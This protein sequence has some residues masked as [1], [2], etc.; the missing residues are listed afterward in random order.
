MNF[1]M[2]GRL[3]AQILTIESLFMLPAL[4]ISLYHNETAA[5]QGFLYTLA[6]M[7]VMA[8]MIVAMGRFNFFMSSCPIKPRF[9]LTNKLC[10]STLQL[11]I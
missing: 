2:M 6:L 11:N 1:K 7:L 4:F 5:V 10:W 9:L 3:M 8:A